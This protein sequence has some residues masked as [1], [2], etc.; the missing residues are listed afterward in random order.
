MRDLGIKPGSET[1][2]HIL[3]SNVG[4]IPCRENYQPVYGMC[5]GPVATKFKE[6]CFELVLYYGKTRWFNPLWERNSRPVYET[7]GTQHHE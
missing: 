3:R 4:S 7:D 6:Y 5:L 1:G 2:A